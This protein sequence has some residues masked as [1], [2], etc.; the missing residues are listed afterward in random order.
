M[1][2][3]EITFSPTGGT[4]KA[5][6]I[7][8]GAISDDV[9]KISLLSRTKESY[10]CN[11]TGS[12][13]C[14]IAVP[15]YAGRVPEAAIRRL[16]RMKAYHTR[17]ILMVVYGNRAYE[18]TMIELKDAAVKAGFLP[19]AAVA[20]IAEHSIMH[21]YAAGRP[22][23]EDQKELKSI[24]KKIAE[25]L[26]SGVRGEDLKVPGN[27]PYKER[28]G[29]PMEIKTSRSCTKCGI[30]AA[31]CPV[32]AISK[33]SP[34]KTNPERCIHCMRCISVCPS[35]SRGVSRFTLFAASMKLR[36]ALSG[37]KENE[38]FI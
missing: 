31:Q 11:F 27:H 12:D 19:I 37:R 24:G 36:K 17:C 21:Q 7:L 3:F 33:K 16:L 2:L 34:D 23:A 9:E 30:C 29:L 14:L 6:D 4:E 28:G 13:V 25:K 1:K 35:H 18:D 5:A 22:D 26:E 38:L 15:S 20:A 32:G 10:S 8:A